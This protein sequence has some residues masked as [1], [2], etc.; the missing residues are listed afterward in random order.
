M[1]AYP[2]DCTPLV[3]ALESD[4]RI[5]VRS[6]HTGGGNFVLLVG[7]VHGVAED[8]GIPVADVTI[9]PVYRED[10]RFIGY[11]G[12]LYI[13]SRHE[14]REDVIAYSDRWLLPTTL[15]MLGIDDVNVDD[16]CTDLDDI[17]ATLGAGWAVGCLGGNN[18]GVT[19]SDGSV[20]V[21][22]DDGW[23]A[24][25]PAFVTVGRQALQD[26]EWSELWHGQIFDPR[27]L[28]DVIRDRA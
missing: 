5:S 14:S 10:G 11:G 19:R 23:S 1:N 3:D 20:I 8:T 15:S 18:Y 21:T 26:E 16:P 9:G 12:D 17:A 13:V 24:F 6:E 4:Y 27:D 7:R 28:I 22:L 2:I 25:L